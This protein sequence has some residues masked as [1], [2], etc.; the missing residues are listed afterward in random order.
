MAILGIGPRVSLVIAVA[1]AALPGLAAWWTGRRLLALR[2]DPALAERFLE[3]RQRLSLVT[4][5]CVVVVG[6]LLPERAL[7]AVPLALLAL[8]AGWFPSRRALFGETW[9]FVGYVAHVLRFWL[10][11]AGFWL[12]LSAAPFLVVSAGRFRWVEAL[13]LGAALLLWEHFHPAILRRL[14]GAVPLSRP[15]LETR[16][17]PVL[18]RSRT[19]SP[20]LYRLARAGGRWANA[21]ALP[22]FHT[23]GVIFG[24]TLLAE[25]EPAEVTAILAHE[26]AH[27]EH[28]DR[29]RLLRLSAL[30]WSAIVLA[31]VAVPVAIVRFPS[32]TAAFV[33]GWVMTLLAYLAI[34]SAGHRAHEADSDRRAVV[35]CGDAEALARAL[36]KLHALSRLPRRW[37]AEIERSA[38]HP[39]LARRIQAIRAAAGIQSAALAAPRVVRTLAPGGYVV[40]EAE[41]V[42][43]LEGVP[44]E[45]PADLS[46]LREHAASVQSVRYSELT[47]LRV[48]AAMGGGAASLVASGRGGFSR[49]APLDSGDVAAVQ[50]A[51]DLV[52]VRLGAEAGGRLQSPAIPSLVASAAVL[53]SI[54]AVGLGT[55][56]M[57]GLIAAIRPTPMALAALGV[58][59][60]GEAALTLLRFGESTAM[61]FTLRR[62]ARGPSGWAG[63][64][65]LAVLGGL[66][67]VLGWARG[68]AAP[69]SRRSSAAL[70]TAPLAALALMAWATLAWTAT[71][72]SPLHWLHEAARAMPSA[73][74]APLGLG[75]ALLAS[76][77]RRWARAGIAVIVVALL[78]VLLGS[79]W[80]G[81]RLGRD[82]LGAAAPPLQMRDA[83]ATLL[84][85]ARVGMPAIALRL[86][87]SGLR[88]A[89]R[90][91]FDMEDDE[92]NAPG[93]SPATSFRIGSFGSAAVDV[94]AE[95]LVFLDDTKALALAR[96]AGGWRV[97]L[98]ELTRP[99]RVSWRIALP[100]L[101]LARL[102]VEP[103]S[104]AWTVSGFD[105][106]SS[107]IV[108]VSGTAGREAMEVNR[109]KRPGSGTRLG[110]VRGWEL[111][112]YAPAAAAA[113]VLTT[114]YQTGLLPWSFLL[115][116]PP[117]RREIW[118]LGPRGATLV[119]ASA[120]PISCP[121][122]PANAPA[123]V[124]VTHAA[125][126]AS[127]WSAEPGS[128]NIR[129]LGS[130]TGRVG[131]L[132]PGPGGRLAGWT[133]ER[134]V[135]VI[136]SAEPA[137]LRIRLPREAG[138][139]AGLY[140]MQGLLGTLAYGRA[141]E[142]TVTVWEI[143]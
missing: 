99:P 121:P 11:A 34:R 76:G 107:E 124:C 51:L 66:A 142:A 50:A 109:W 31:V 87:P 62:I 85:Q 91:A 43:W 138:R 25:L 4:I 79:G 84:R 136:D 137:A 48:R 44:T 17:A 26:V 125:A 133:D 42:T 141:K 77:N 135:L 12:T 101:G 32:Y 106:R 72:G 102:G 55:V 23:P 122:A 96:G 70:V 52:D 18:E 37:S 69:D 7:W 139:P 15:D 29:R 93:A 14:V 57:P 130:V 110:A 22:S 59:A 6:V 103:A 24:E 65:G 117:V 54:Y 116:I 46:A 81:G 82:P 80:I 98:H 83:T 61:E 20:R 28:Y 131:A 45:T 140:P 127:F 16:F 120:Q 123:R 27:L 8:L 63:I 115:P 2:D 92:D 39:S 3:R 105:A 35:L 132:T 41:R 89:V 49:S 113:I 86:S 134:T 9:G 111:L 10:A 21:L 60:L 1:L 94:E 88:F 143:R 71:L 97:E 5:S 112:A 128:G 95:D 119:A 68:R 47:E 58:T 104:G 30:N 36:S 74:L 13:G 129:A 19:L 67:L 126:A 75:A 38:T 100:E 73:A 114:E 78:P 53:V 90:Q 40:L 108:A 56:L 118:A 64:G 33:W